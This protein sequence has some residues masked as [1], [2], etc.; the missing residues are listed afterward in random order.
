[1]SKILKQC[2]H[3]DKDYQRYLKSVNYIP[4]SPIE[5]K[6]WNAIWRKYKIT[7]QEYDKLLKRQ[8]GVC[9]G[10]GLIPK[11]M[12]VDHDHTTGKVRGLLCADC[13]MALGLIRDNPLTLQRLTRYLKSHYK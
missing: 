9:K 2:N 8:K 5:R 3:S 7:Q 1:M 11:K 12:C 13:N 4:I 10:C 6:R